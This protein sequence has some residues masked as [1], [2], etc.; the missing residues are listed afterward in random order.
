[1]RLK[2]HQHVLPHHAGSSRFENQSEMFPVARSLSRWLVK[3]RYPVGARILPIL[4][5]HRVLPEHDPLQPAMPHAAMLDEQ[6]RA[7]SQAFN[8]LPLAEA[9]ERLRNGT[10]PAGAA[11]ITFDD[12]YRD[13]HDIALP[14]LKRHKLPA[15]VFVASGYLD[16]GRMFN[17]TVIEGVR[18]LPVG[19]VN[20]SW[21]G[22]GKRQI[23]DLASRMALIHEL[24]LAVKYMTPEQRT[25]FCAEL[26]RLAGAP[27]PDNLMMSSDQ[28]RK[29]AR[30]GVDIGGHTVRHPILATLDAKTAKQEICDNYTALRD[31]TGTAPRCFAYPN[32]KPQRDYTAEHARMVEQAGY[33]TAVSTAVGV[34]PQDAD[35]FQLPRFM[36]RERH[37]I[38]FIAR[39]LR[40]A[41]HSQ[42]EYAR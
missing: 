36:P 13:N 31:L 34:A 12:G 26:T 3:T 21:I 11:C 28:V 20:L 22:A 35:R 25:E 33:V 27:L 19:E 30:E 37:A 29:M 18:R 5:Y 14:L 17:D 40:M 32:G 8:V 7:L 38:H 15:T 16:G 1:M 23:S 24:T 41:S 6:F 42:A 4:M 2:L 10:L 39:M 9:A